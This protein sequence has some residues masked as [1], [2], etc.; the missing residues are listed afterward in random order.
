MAS[1][2]KAV[3]STSSGKRKKILS[4]AAKLELIKAHERGTSLKRLMDQYN[5]STSVIYEIL[6]DK[7][8]VR[9]FMKM[10]EYS[11]KNEHLEDAVYK[12][13]EQERAEGVPV[14]GIDIQLAA[15]R[16]AIQLGIE[17]FKCT[18][19]WV[20]RF[21]RHHASARGRHKL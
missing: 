5:I 9:E 3:P 7:E 18:D 10:I 20:W 8:R 6:R 12:W 19:G 4:N 16:L 21:R 1:K 13:Y 17:D 2:D 15:Q 11:K 14:R